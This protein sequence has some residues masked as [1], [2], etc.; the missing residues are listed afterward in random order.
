MPLLTA[1]DQIRPVKPLSKF[2][3]GIPERNLSYYDF[4]S[5]L[6]VK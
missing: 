1:W 5:R 2:T 6:E 3:D 4:A